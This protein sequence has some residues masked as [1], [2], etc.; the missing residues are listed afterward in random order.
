VKFWNWNIQK[1][2][3]SGNTVNS[4]PMASSL[5]AVYRCEKCARK[6]WDWPVGNEWTLSV[7]WK[8]QCAT[9]WTL[10]KHYRIVRLDENT[11]EHSVSLTTA[12]ILL[13]SVILLT[14]PFIA[15]ASSAHS[16]QVTFTKDVAPIFFKSC[17]ECHRPGEAAPFSV[18][19]YKDVRPWAKSIREKVIS[20][21]M[22]PW[23]A[24]P[25][26]GE[27][28]N[29]PR[30]TQQEI[31]TILAWIDDGAKEGIAS[32][33]PPVPKFTEGW[34]IGQP[35]LVLP[36][37]V[38]HTL[39]K[40]AADQYVNA[41]LD[42]KLTE[43]SYVQAVE[44]LP[45]NREIV[46]HAMLL[47]VPPGKTAWLEADAPIFETTEG[48]VKRL[49]ADVPV[50]NDGCQ[51]PEG[52]GTRGLKTEVLTVYVPG[53]APDHWT[54]PVHIPAGSK[55]FLQMHYSNE[56]QKSGP[57]GSENR[58]RTKIGIRF[59]KGK[60]P[61]K[62]T[63][64]EVM[65]N[66]FFK[67]PAGEERHK[68]SACWTAREDNVE[69][70]ALMPHMHLRGKSM[71]VMAIYPDCQSEVLLNVPKYEYRWQTNY[72]FKKPKPIPKGTT[73]TITAI[74]DN[75]AKNKYNP[76]PTKDVRWDERTGGEMLAC[77]LELIKPQ[78]VEVRSAARTSPTSSK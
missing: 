25:N 7:S 43:D 55:I 59:A 1:C 75:S 14:I 24:D 63:T 71:E 47:S 48:G 21:E 2:A 45:E 26:H 10:P 38:E 49:K 68:A 41:L 46:H 15:P 18:M 50:H 53:R 3:G 58:D 64:T 51:L 70:A 34:R 78:L 6:W 73:I 69:L 62:I 5:G 9:E 37:P 23:H 66:L 61:E 29:D 28:A 67:I 40:T 32:D 39:P 65:A 77:F 27:F 60:A 36:M 16:N 4:V 8:C 12:S 22:P 76:D 13:I 52:G 11:K 31:D 35:D 20:R 33:L 57:D 19:S 30:L 44:V 56:L 17:A 74:F 72:R 54:H 42:P